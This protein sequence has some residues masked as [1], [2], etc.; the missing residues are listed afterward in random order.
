M[1]RILPNPL[2]DIPMNRLWD[3]VEPMVPITACTSSMLW[4][5]ARAAPLSSHWMADSNQE[6]DV[7]SV[8]PNYESIRPNSFLKSCFIWYLYLKALIFKTENYIDEIAVVAVRK[9]PRITGTGTRHRSR[10]NCT[11]CL[12]ADKGQ[13][14]SA[15]CSGACGRDYRP[16]PIPG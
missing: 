4:K 12:L 8:V 3:V 1:K 10:W 16:T 9:E 5:L 6:R 13:R 2:L 15:R 11:K 7:A 14:C